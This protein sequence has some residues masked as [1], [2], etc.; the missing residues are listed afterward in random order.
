MKTIFQ[1]IQFDE[2]FSLKWEITTEHWEDLSVVG[3]AWQ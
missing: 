3:T 1:T 2:Q